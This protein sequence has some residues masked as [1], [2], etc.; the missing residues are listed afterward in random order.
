VDIYTAAS[1]Q[2]P[3]R[4]PGTARTSSTSLVGLVEAATA[5]AGI[6]LRRSL[7]L[8]RTDSPGS[9]GSPPLPLLASTGNKCSGYRTTG[10][11][12]QV[13]YPARYEL[14]MPGG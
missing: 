11:T 2:P 6:P 1:L 4:C 5:I 10:R 8:L 12:A 13:A 9:S 3:Y 7:S 14:V